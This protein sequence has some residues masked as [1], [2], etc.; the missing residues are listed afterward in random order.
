MCKTKNSYFKRE[1]FFYFYF[2]RVE[3]SQNINILYLI[4]IVTDKKNIFKIYIFTENNVELKSI[5]FNYR[6][7]SHIVNIQ[8]LLKNNIF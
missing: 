2:I 8:K 5:L 7:L 6:F 3:S 4:V 1:Y